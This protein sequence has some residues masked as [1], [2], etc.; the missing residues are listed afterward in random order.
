MSLDFDGVSFSYGKRSGPVLDRVS[1][2][3]AEGSLHGLLGP[4]GAGKSTIAKTVLG[5][6]AKY[7]GRITWLGTD[8]ASISEL[9]RA[10]TFAYVP[11]GGSA[12]FSLT[13][14]E[15]VLLG[16]TPHYAY[17]P[18]ANDWDIVRRVIADFGLQDLVNRDVADLSGGQAQRVTIARAVAQETAVILLDEPTSALDLK[19]QVETLDILRELA[20]ERQVTS[21]V[22]IHDLNLAAQFF[23]RITIIDKGAVAADGAPAEVLTPDTIRTIYDVDVRLVTDGRTSYIKPLSKLERALAVV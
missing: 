9:E 23:D 22:A 6:N 7:E 3:V 4:N 5:I 16:R 8:I 15:A 20:S 12:P 18:S 17:A 21:V 19:Y 2:A 1:F 11:Q 13:V 10:K 14:Q